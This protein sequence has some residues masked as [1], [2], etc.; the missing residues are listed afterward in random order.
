MTYTFFFK[1]KEPNVSLVNIYE[2]YYHDDA[3]YTLPR[4]NIVYNNNI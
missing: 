3:R 4:L 2:N 1:C